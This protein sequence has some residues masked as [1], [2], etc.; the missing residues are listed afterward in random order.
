VDRA[1]GEDMVE[2]VADSAKVWWWVSPLVSLVGGFGGGLLGSYLSKRQKF[3]ELKRDTAVEIMRLF[4]S[5][6]EAAIGMYD[7]LKIVNRL[8]GEAAPSPEQKQK[9]QA[10]HDSAQKQF[11][12]GIT[13]LWQLQNIAR[14]VFPIGVYQKMEAVQSAMSELIGDVYGNNQN[15]ISLMNQIVEK[16]ENASIAIRQ[17]LK[18]N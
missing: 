14:L 3:W 11:Q 17:E 13:Q 5:Q 12:A 4:G 15:F 8:Q 9:A 16:Q 7:A 2:Q 1:E 18:V 10:K 6:R